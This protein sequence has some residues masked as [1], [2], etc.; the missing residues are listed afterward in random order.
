M[1]D[2]KWEGAWEKEGLQLKAPP[3]FRVHLPWGLVSVTPYPW[4]SA[5][6]YEVRD[7]VRVLLVDP[8]KNPGSKKRAPAGGWG[9]LGMGV[10]WGMA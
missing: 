1:S 8:T 2:I 9:V 7:S 6:V 3:G 10:G 5:H 4:F